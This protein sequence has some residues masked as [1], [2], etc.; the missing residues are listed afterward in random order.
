MD[1]CVLHKVTLSQQM[2]RHSYIFETDI[3]VMKTCTVSSHLSDLIPIFLYVHI[4][5]K[6]KKE[7][8]SV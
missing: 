3:F 8:L 4:I 7:K 2:G 1:T 6:K 5:K